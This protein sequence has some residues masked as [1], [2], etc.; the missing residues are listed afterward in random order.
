[1]VTSYI[2]RYYYLVSNQAS[3][4]G[5]NVHIF[6][7]YHWTVITVTLQMSC[8]QTKLTIMH[9]CCQNRTSCNTYC[10][11]YYQIGARGKYSHKFGVYA[12][13]ANCLMGIWKMYTHICSTYEVFAINFMTRGT[14]HIFDI[15]LKKLTCHTANIAHTANM[16][17]RYIAHHNFAQIW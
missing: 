16:P 11:F 10:T 4:P 8:H 2:L 9:I 13:N 15:L 14:V 17:N 5:V 3:T 6:D 1:M 12:T 7:I